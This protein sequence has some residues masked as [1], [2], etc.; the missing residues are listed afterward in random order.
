MV[1][2][3]GTIGIYDARY[4]CSK[5]MQL[6]VS[7]ASMTKQ[8]LLESISCMFQQEYADE[9]WLVFLLRDDYDATNTVFHSSHIKDT[10]E[11]SVYSCVPS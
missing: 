3:F 11:V 7:V 6:P 8:Q 2:G 10:I 4:N 5:P 9:D 1:A